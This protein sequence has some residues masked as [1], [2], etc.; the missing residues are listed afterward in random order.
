M[1][2]EQ[3]HQVAPKPPEMASVSKLNYETG[4]LP[5]Q[6]PC[7]EHESWYSFVCNWLAFGGFF[8]ISISAA[9]VAG[10]ICLSLPQAAF[11]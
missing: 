5:P 4:T 6:D 2:F 1:K 7:N 11:R 10:A 3:G 9:A 8:W